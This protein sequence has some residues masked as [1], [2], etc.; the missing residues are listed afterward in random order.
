MIITENDQALIF[1]IPP[2]NQIC[3]CCYSYSRYTTHIDA[4]GH[5]CRKCLSAYQIGQKLKPTTN[6]DSLSILTRDP[7]EDMIK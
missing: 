2:D 1:K 4:R 6:G 5:V 7:Q 3:D